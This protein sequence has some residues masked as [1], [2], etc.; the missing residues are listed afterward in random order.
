ME[1]R[2]ADERTRALF[3]DDRLFTKRFGK[4]ATKKRDRRLNEIANYDNVA[5]LLRL[6]A[7]GPG[8]WH[9]LDGRDGGIDTGKISGDLTGS[10]RI[11]LAPPTGPLGDTTSVIIIEI[12]DTH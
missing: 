1:Y 5:E 12:K 3:E 6:G 8:R 10:L 9:V 7:Q 11:L 2:Y 4:S